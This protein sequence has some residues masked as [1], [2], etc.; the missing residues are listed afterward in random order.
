[1]TA[2]P[3]VAEGHANGAARWQIQVIVMFA[4]DLFHRPHVR[5]ATQV[6]RGRGT[7]ACATQKS[8]ALLLSHIS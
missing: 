4:L 3:G 2:G 1:M 5:D 7:K 8:A 6:P